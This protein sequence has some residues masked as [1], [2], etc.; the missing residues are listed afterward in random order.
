[1]AAYFIFRDDKANGA[2]A[3]EKVKLGDA[4]PKQWEKVSAKYDD[5]VD[6]GQSSTV[7]LVFKEGT[8]G[9]VL[10]EHFFCVDELAGSGCDAIN[11]LAEFTRAVWD[12]AA[13]AQIRTLQKGLK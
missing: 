6:E 3:I 2:I 5:G 7:I 4:I 12:A 8:P 13:E 9:A 11:S 10:C 1:M